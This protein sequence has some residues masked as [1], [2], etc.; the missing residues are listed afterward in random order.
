[1]LMSCSTN[2]MPILSWGSASL[3]ALAARLPIKLR[4]NI[5]CGALAAGWR[6]AMAGSYIRLLRSWLAY[7]RSGSWLD[8]GQWTYSEGLGALEATGW[9]PSPVW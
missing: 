1:M 9:R 3:E 2:Q 8:R 6:G 4:V 5:P 7:M